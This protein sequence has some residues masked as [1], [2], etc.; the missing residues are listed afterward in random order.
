MTVTELSYRSAGSICRVGE[1]SPLPDPA[2]ICASS[3][4][5]MRDS[6]GL[7]TEDRRQPRSSALV[8]REE[9]LEVTGRAGQAP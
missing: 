7:P 9:D 3:G 2:V 6:G 1:P 5:F 4:T 8:G